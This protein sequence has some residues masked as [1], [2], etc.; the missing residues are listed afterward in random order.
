MRKGAWPQPW[1]SGVTA[2]T[3]GERLRPV[4]STCCPG[5]TGATTSIRLVMIAAV[6]PLSLFRPAA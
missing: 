3:T 6:L 1:R 5:R 2:R 4:S